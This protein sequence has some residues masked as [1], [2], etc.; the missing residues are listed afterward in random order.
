MSYSYEIQNAPVDMSD[1]P[2]FANMNEAGMYVLEAEQIMFNE[3]MQNIG[4]SELG[5]IEK[6]GFFNE[7]DDAKEE[8]KKANLKETI[9]SFLTRVWAKIKAMFETL[10]RKIKEIIAKVATVIASKKAKDK[11]LVAALDSKDK[12][13]VKAYKYTGLEDRVESLVTGGIVSL[14]GPAEK[15]VLS[16]EER[17]KIV[18]DIRGSEKPE[19]LDKAFIKSNLTDIISTVKDFKNTNNV[20]KKAYDKT[21]KAIDENVKNVKKSDDITKVGI[22]NVHTEASNLISVSNIIVAEWYGYVRRNAAIVSKLASIAKKNDDK[23]DDKKS[24]NESA[25]YQSE[26]GSLFDWN[27]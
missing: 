3:M 1:I 22:N 11:D 26:I 24:T 12:F 14:N 5:A 16:K 20:I 17:K 2:S 4:L 9:V 27:L 21:K 18:N 25:A 8:K 13:E 19:T 15:K 7:A 23:N 10:L 6:N